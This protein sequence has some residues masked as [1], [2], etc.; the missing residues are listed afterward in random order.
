MAFKMARLGRGPMVA[1]S[2]NTFQAA[3][4]SPL[5]KRRRS[6]AAIAERLG[7]FPER[8]TRASTWSASAA[9]PAARNAW[10]ASRS[11]ACRTRALPPVLPW[12][13]DQERRSAEAA[14]RSAARR[15][16]AKGRSAD[17][18]AARW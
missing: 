1:I 12:E 5:R 11:A 9:M 10:S 15:V 7:V 8:R 16:A 6:N 3:R 14:G 17:A 2:S 4:T 13:D 18:D